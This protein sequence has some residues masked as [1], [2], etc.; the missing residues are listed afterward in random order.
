M[1]AVAP[2]TLRHPR[3]VL[4][5]ALLLG[6]AL[7]LGF[8]E[9]ALRLVAP[10]GVIS[11]G[12]TTSDNG[13]RYGWGFDGGEMQVV[14]D[15]DSGQLY[16]NAA[17][18][19]GW[20]DLPR[21]FG[22]PDGVFRV[23]VLGDSN[24]FGYLVPADQTIT[25]RLEDKLKAMG[26]RAEVINMAYSGW[27]TDQEVEALRQEGLRYRPDVVVLHMTG[28]DLMDNFHWSLG[29]KFGQRRPFYYVAT[30]DGLA[31][32]QVNP[33]YKVPSGTRFKE[34]L[35]RHSEVVKRVYTGWKTFLAL[36]RSKY[37]VSRG[38][39]ELIGYFL[40]AGQQQP[41]LEALAGLVGRQDVSEQQLTALISAHGLDDR[42]EVL[43]RMA[44]RVNSQ[45]GVM[46][47]VYNANV[48]WDSKQWNLFAALVRTAQ[49]EVAAT[50]AALVL[51][52][53]FDEGRWDWE[54]YWHHVD[55]SA[56]AKQRYFSI[57][58]DLRRLAA[59]TGIGFVEPRLKSRRA[60]NDAHPNAA[61]NDAI[62]ENML[63][64][65][66]AQGLLPRP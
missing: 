8:L 18:P 39:V 60:R 26:I 15:A 56:E 48:G 55:P 1:T 6:L 37:E 3:L 31:E 46:A 40:G 52:S 20:R 9:L 53:D 54:M 14:R 57:N 17:N 7:M 58:D 21:S 30:P 66:K 27:G 65:L 11:V 24:I 49:R 33:N 2:P 35:F 45:E 38:Q 13:R 16:L 44:E 25:R 28:N 12:W 32:R 36:R 43:L 22:K 4:A 63:N 47:G 34:F 19:Q 62:A 10:Y 41:F 23:L 29:G 50:G 51:S 64:G 42:R 5:V 61:G 59:E